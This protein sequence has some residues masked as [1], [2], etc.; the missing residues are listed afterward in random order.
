MLSSI[1]WKLAVIVISFSAIAKQIG[2]FTK[3]IN[4]WTLVFYTTLSNILVIIFFALA[5]ISEALFSPES[6]FYAFM[7]TPA[8]RFA[9]MMC[10]T[11]TCFIYHFLLSPFDRKRGKEDNKNYF[12]T[13]GNLA[14]HYITPIMNILDYFMFKGEST[15]SY[16]V[17][18]GWT[19]IPLVY[20]AFFYI[21]AHFWGNIGEWDTA[22]P[23]F[24]FDVKKN[25]LKKTIL[26]IVAIY[27]VFFLIGNV[28]YGIGLLI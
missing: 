17:T 8:A 10:I 18:V 21:R 4:S 3:K 28:M 14:V 13:F 20:I 1:L 22:Y 11:L 2:L 6:T 23:Y 9:V 27:I 12:W 25:G 15:P 7:H 19:F 24:F 26:Y 16:L 5:V